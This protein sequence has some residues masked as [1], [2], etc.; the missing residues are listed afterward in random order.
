[1]HEERSANETNVHSTAW[2]APTAQIFGRVTIGEGS[3]LW[4][5]AVLRAECAE[6]R[7]GRMSNLQDFVMVHVGYEHPTVVGDFCS[8]THHATLHGATIEDDC[9]I[10]V[11]ATLMDGVVVG[12]GSIVAGGAVLKEGSI[13]PPGSIIAGIPAKVVRQRD[14]AHANRLNAW[15]YHRNAQ[16]YRDGRH[17]AWRGEEYLRWLDEITRNVESDA[18]LERFP[19]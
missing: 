8:I 7:V 16:F 10:G 11:N 12:R 13:F 1:M 6:I 5:N 9:L 17:D 14:S 3:S 2:C 15:Q 19:R 4:H 18:D